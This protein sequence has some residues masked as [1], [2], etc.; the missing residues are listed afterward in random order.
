[1]RVHGKGIVYSN[2]N[3]SRWIY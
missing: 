3:Y 1:M 2:P